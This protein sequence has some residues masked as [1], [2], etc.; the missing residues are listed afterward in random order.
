M[1]VIHN[2]TVFNVRVHIYNI[3]DTVNPWIACDPNQ[4]GLIIQRVRVSLGQS[5]RM[6]SALIRSLVFW[7]LAGIIYFTR[8][9]DFSFFF[10]GYLADWPWIYSQPMSTIL[11][12]G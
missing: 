9:F 1:F 10:A 7:Y 12:S 5:G 8:F 3:I 4:C 6:C 2:V 11:E